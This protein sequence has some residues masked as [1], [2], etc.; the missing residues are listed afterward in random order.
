MRDV[1]RPKMILFDYGHTLLWEKDFDFL[2]GYRAMFELVAENSGNASP[3]EACALSVGIFRDADVCRKLGYEIHEFQLLRLVADVFG[4]KFSAPLEQVESILWT[5]ASKGGKMPHVD[6]LL[7]YL[8]EE[9]IRTGIISNIGWSGGALKERI[10]RFFPGNDFEFVIASSEYAIRKPNP[11]IFRVALQKAGLNPSEVWF[12]GD[13]IGADIIGA[14]G[15][16]IFPVYY[17]CAA[18]KDPYAKS[19]I[20]VDFECLHIC[21]WNELV[22]VLRNNHI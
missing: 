10:D 2:S 3:E 13:N 12:C 9:G 14:H 4:I 1:M 19:D 8:K 22:D 6:E 21:D 5:N 18:E 17:D 11:L 20:Q 16:G 7:K 15:A